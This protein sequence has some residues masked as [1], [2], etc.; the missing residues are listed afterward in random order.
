MKVVCALLDTAEALSPATRMAGHELGQRVAQL[1][2]VPQSSALAS[3]L[4][5]V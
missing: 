5:F 3:K 1:G 2:S 4:V